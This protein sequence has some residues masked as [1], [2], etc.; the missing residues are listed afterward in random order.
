MHT[1]LFRSEDYFQSRKTRVAIGRQHRQTILG[2]HR[3]EFLEIVV[4]L[5]GFGVHTVGKYR[6]R[7]EAGDVLVIGDSQAHA[8]RQTCNLNLVNIFVRHDFV[9]RIGRGFAELPGY[10]EIF[11]GTARRGFPG[12]VRLSLAELEQAE[13]WLDGLEREIALGGRVAN[14]LEEAYLTLLIGLISRRDGR[15]AVE[16]KGDVASDLGRIL[17][18]IEKNLHRPL[19]VADMA[20]EAGM[21]ERTFHRKF[22]QAFQISPGKYLLEARIRRA[23]DLLRHHGPS[24]QVGEIAR[25]CGFEDVSYFTRCFRRV[26][27]TTPGA[28]RRKAA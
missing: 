2:P 23:E 25:D 5:S 16:R 18:A 22:L 9:R 17:S 15:F 3:H 24:R 28:L 12:H 11:G 14:R 19:L 8:Y 1:Q 10:R 6:H 7:V 26:T 4:I 21:S 13:T 27:G 20:A